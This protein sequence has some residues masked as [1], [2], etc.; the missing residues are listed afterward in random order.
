[1]IIRAIGGIEGKGRESYE[2]ETGF[3]GPNT[4]KVQLGNLPPIRTEQFAGYAA[5]TMARIVPTLS[6]EV[7]RDW[8]THAH[9]LYEGVKDL[10]EKQITG[11]YYDPTTRT[12]LADLAPHMDIINEARA[13]ELD[14]ALS[15]ALTP[16]DPTADYKENPF[17][18]GPRENEISFAYNGII[19]HV[20]DREDFYNLVLRVLGGGLMGWGKY[21]TFKEVKMAARAINR[22]LNPP[23]PTAI[24]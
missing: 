3:W 6:D 23:R 10:P 1:M 17:L 5:L 20:I 16:V 19:R 8:A 2:I 9:E 11:E 24:S 18:V 22:L 4:G 13:G 7:R 12:T 15:A 14:A 21:G